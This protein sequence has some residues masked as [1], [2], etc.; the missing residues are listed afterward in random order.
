MMRQK[1]MSYKEVILKVYS[2][3]VEMKVLWGVLGGKCNYYI[4][5][6]GHGIAF[7]IWFWFVSHS[8]YSHSYLIVHSFVL[9]EG[10][11]ALCLWSTKPGWA[12]MERMWHVQRPSWSWSGSLAAFKKEKRREDRQ[13]PGAAG[14][15]HNATLT[16]NWLCSHT[17]QGILGP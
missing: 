13:G 12:S 16:C 15:S 11:P 17:G 7:K 10:S 8:K 5:F 1:S 4:I 6:F 14:V 9:K 2:K 3:N